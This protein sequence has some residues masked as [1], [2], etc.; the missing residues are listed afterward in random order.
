PVRLVDTRSGIGAPL[1]QVAAHCVLRV[2][3]DDSSAP[4]GATAAVL[5]VTSAG[6]PRPT[7]LTVYACGSDR[8]YVSHLNPRPNDPVP[9]LAIVPVDATRAACIYVDDATDVLVDLTGWYAPVGSPLHELTPLRVLDTRGGPR[10]PG[11]APGRPGDG[12]TI[13]IPLAGRALPAQAQAVAAVV[14]LTNATQATFATAAPCGSAPG[15]STVNTLPGLD[16]GAPAMVG[17]GV[18]GDLC[19]YLDRSADVIVDITGWYG[20]NPLARGIPLTV[21]G[22]PLRELEARRLADSR[23]GI[24]GWS[25][26][27]ASG[28]IRSL[29]LLDTVAVGATAVEME[30]IAVDATSSGY[31]TAYPCGATPPT[32]SV[33]N[34]RAGATSAESS[35]VTVGLGAGGEVCLSSFGSTHVIVDLIAVHGTSSALRT[36]GAAPG[37][38]RSPLPGQPDHTVHCPVDGGPIRIAALAA[39][40]AK[41]SVAGGAAATSVDITRTMAVDEVVTIDTTG[42]AGTEHAFLRCLPADFPAL[43]A[44]GVSPTPGWYRAAEMNPSPFAFILDEY[45]VPVWYKRTPYPVIGLFA[46]GPNG[47]AWRWWTGGGMPTETEQ[48]GIERRSLDGSLVGTLTLPGEAVDWHEYLRLPNGHRLIVVYTREPLPEPQ[49]VPCSDGSGVTRAAT[50]MVN[51]DVVE[52]DETGTEV[53]RWR[54]NDHV[55]DSENMLDACFDLDP[56]APVVWGLDLLHINAVDVFPDGDLLVTARHLDAVLRID[57]ATGTVEWKLGGTA[58]MEGVGLTIADDPL[59]GPVAPHDGRVLPNGNITMH[60]NRTGA[61]PSWS[62]AVEYDL[63]ANTASL[64]WSYS[65]HF[66]TGTLGSARRLTDGSTVIG[67][68]N[69]SSPWFEQVLADGTLGLT[70]DVP[71]G[72]GIYRAEA[73][74]VADFDRATLRNNAGGAAPPAP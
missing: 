4:T 40:G 51:G 30:V 49:T 72:T 65:T 19:V 31:L 44:A 48:L 45:G 17:L 41:V 63:Q 42:P 64:V 29:R 7:F 26:R 6:A 52:L 13:R 21:P 74:P 32:A 8:P 69:A 16:R 61:T 20:E 46:D 57:K 5:T 71:G 62:R 35:M 43:S 11:L 3:L 67:W 15:T 73:S 58:P 22:G 1:A 66:S 27:F 18:G 38:D 59:Q 53:W 60:D 10:T 47:V 39:P 70:V 12:T 24:G 68:G 56:G 28:E 23:N 25:T 14:T 9:G 54:S 36:L 34:F 2:E 37:L 55:A 50:V 33:V